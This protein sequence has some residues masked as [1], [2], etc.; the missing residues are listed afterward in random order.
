MN[1]SKPKTKFFASKAAIGLVVFTFF[2]ALALW[3]G[4][5]IAF[6]QG[7]NEITPKQEMDWIFAFITIAVIVYICSFLFARQ[8]CFYVIELTEQSI[9]R[10]LFNR[11]RKLEIKW[12][13]IKEIRCYQEF[14]VVLFWTVPKK[15]NTVS[16]TISKTVQG[17]NALSGAYKKND[18][19]CVYN[20]DYRKLNLIRKYTKQELINLPEW[21]KNKLQDID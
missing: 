7:G 3:I 9:K 14:G 17:K 10:T 20:C 13:D 21:I 1:K 11:F 4:A 6:L 8:N 12:G 15:S 16:L 2:V 5:F 19:I 18:T